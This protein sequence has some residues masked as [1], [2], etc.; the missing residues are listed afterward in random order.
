[1]LI[2]CQINTLLEIKATYIV[3]KSK[4]LMCVGGGFCKAG[5]IHS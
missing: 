5:H 1:M 3:L 2:R 4:V